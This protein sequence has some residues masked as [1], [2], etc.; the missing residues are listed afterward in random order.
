MTVQEIQILDHR[1]RAEIRAYAIQLTADHHRADD[2]LQDVRYLVLKYRDRF[3]AGTNFTAWV[4]TIVR[5]TFLSDY[6]KRQRRRDLLTHRPPHNQWASERT[7]HNQAESSLAIQDIMGLIDQLPHIYRRAF[8]LH[9]RGLQYKEIA[10]LTGIPSGTAKSRVFH[11]RS[12]LRDQLRRR[13]FV[14]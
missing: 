14:N 2:L 1:H 4:K 6:R 9:L 13:G 3:Q 8:L 12:V 11:A 7:V 5:N 10:G